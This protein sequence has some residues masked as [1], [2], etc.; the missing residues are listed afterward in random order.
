KVLIGNIVSNSLLLSLEGIT[1][2]QQIKDFISVWR[3]GGMYRKLAARVLEID[4][5]IAL[6]KGR[7]QVISRL[8]RERNVALNEMQNKSM[9]EF[10]EAGLM[11]SIV[12]DTN[13]YKEDS[14]F[15]SDLDKKIDKLVE[16]VPEQVVTAF[17]WALMSPGTPMH[18]FMAHSTQFSDLAAKYSLIKHR[19]AKGDS[20]SK[21]IAAAQDAFINYDV[22]TGKGLDYMNK[23][24]LFMFTKFI[25]RFQQ[26]I[27][28]QLNTRAGS[29]VAQHFAV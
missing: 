12:E 3:N 1:P 18:N 5:E 24:G 26:A 2:S 27:A 19:M 7:A 23:M 11:S 13:V 28:R 25:I 4:S 16:N 21:A 6:N 29:A 14:G 20:Q 17:N 10:M 22:P 9:H 15:K 8:N